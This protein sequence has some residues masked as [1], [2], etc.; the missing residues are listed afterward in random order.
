MAE[1]AHGRLLRGR[2]NTSFYPVQGSLTQFPPSTLR[3]TETENTP[4]QDKGMV[5]PDS[6][7]VP[8]SGSPEMGG[9]A[10]RI[11]AISYPK[12]PELLCS[13]RLGETSGNGAERED[14][15]IKG[16]WRN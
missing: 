2:K 4:P 7:S 15:K 1:G 12:S 6:P 11:T 5:T 14:E 10:Q 9:T 13:R 8:S 16:G 3:G